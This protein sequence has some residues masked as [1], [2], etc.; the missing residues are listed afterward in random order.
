MLLV[1]IY[2][3]LAAY[4]TGYL[5]LPMES[6]ETIID[7]AANVAT[8]DGKGSRVHS[9]AK[10]G[11]GSGTGGGEKGHRTMGSGAGIKEARKREREERRQ[12]KKRAR[13]GGVRDWKKI[14]S[15]G[16]DAC[17][18]VP[19]GGVCEVLYGEGR[20]IDPDDEMEEDAR[21]YCG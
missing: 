11:A 12:E 19:L 1:Y 10:K 4:N 20:D 13:E 9:S 17:L 18:D 7:E 5:T 3:A 8:I 2:V 16:T 6:I 14:W 15:T 21:L